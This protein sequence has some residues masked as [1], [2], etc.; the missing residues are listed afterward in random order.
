LYG[1]GLALFDPDLGPGQ[2]SVIGA[3]PDAALYGAL[4]VHAQANNRFALADVAKTDTVSLMEA[5]GLLMRA[6]TNVEYG[7]V[8]GPWAVVPGPAGVIGGTARQVPASAVIAGLCARVDE[9][10]NPN[11]AAAGRDFPFQYATGLVLPVGKADREAMLNSGV[12]PLGTIKGV[13]EGYGFQTAMLANPDNPYW[14]ANCSRAR[15]YLKSRAEARGEPYA[16]R[17]IDGRQ[18]LQQRL[19]TDLEEE[20]L[21]FYQADGLY[22]ATARDAFSIEVGASV[23]TVNTIAQGE[24][25]AVAEVVYSMHAKAVIIDLVTVPLGGKVSGS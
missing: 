8:F 10:G 3:T 11:R 4:T 9:L 24:L 19:K 16:F 21:Q 1:D 15:M 18:R 23:N 14:Q 7:A 5:K 17:P 13:L 22:G 25:H 20:F 2:V 6:V 12:N